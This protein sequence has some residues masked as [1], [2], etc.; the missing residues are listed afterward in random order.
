[1]VHHIIAGSDWVW[2]HVNFLNLYNDDPNDRGIAV[3]TVCFDDFEPRQPPI[4]NP[5]FTQ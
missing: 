1:V 4:R 2:A 3:Q 5:H